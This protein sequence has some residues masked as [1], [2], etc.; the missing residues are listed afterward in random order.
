MSS[1]LKSVIA[2]VVLVACI[3]V[4]VSES[5]VTKGVLS[6]GSDTFDKVRNGVNLSLELNH[7]AL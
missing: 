1:I 6:L 5:A 4:H 7:G 3:C 2:Y